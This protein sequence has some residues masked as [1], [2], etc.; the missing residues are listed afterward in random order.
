MGQLSLSVLVA[1]DRPVVARLQVGRDDVHEGGALVLPGYRR[2]RVESG[3]VHR[4]LLDGRV[5]HDADTHPT[6]VLQGL[7]TQEVVLEVNRSPSFR[8]LTPKGG[9]SVSPTPGWSRQNFPD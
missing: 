6:G 4:H 1:D 5:A 8:G 2:F 7:G 9:E 3:A